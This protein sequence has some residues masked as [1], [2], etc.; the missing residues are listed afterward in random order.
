MLAR[1]CREIDEDARHALALEKAITTILSVRVDEQAVK[2]WIHA[3]DMTEKDLNTHHES[4]QLSIER[5]Q[6]VDALLR[7]NT[8]LRIMRKEKDYEA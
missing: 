4:I 1:A 6:Q 2:G 8:K 3:T 7:E 5:L